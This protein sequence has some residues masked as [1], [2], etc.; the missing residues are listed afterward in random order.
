MY[1]AEHETA[2]TPTWQSMRQQSTTR[3]QM[4]MS[5]SL[6]AWELFWWSRSMSSISCNTCTH[7]EV[8]GLEP[9]AKPWARD[10]MN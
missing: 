9:H 4:M 10:Q 6:D 7:N 1:L 3:S 2:A 5:S 8:H